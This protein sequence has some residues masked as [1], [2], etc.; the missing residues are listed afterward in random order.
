[1]K[2]K[3]ERELHTLIPSDAAQSC[4]VS[5]STAT[6]ATKEAFKLSPKDHI[7]GVSK[8]DVALN[9]EFSI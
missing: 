2:L 3:K 7:G 6:I 5:G 4:K 8:R 9:I 1:M